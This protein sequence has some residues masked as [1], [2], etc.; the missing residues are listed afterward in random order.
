MQLN[1]RMLIKTAGATALSGLAITGGVNLQQPG[2]PYTAYGQGP[3]QFQKVD[4]ADVHIAMG[5]FYFQVVDVEDGEVTDRQGKNALIEL[6]SAQELLVRFFNEGNAVHEAHFGRNP[7]PE[8]LKSYQENLF[9]GGAAG[10]GFIGLHLDPGQEGMLH[11]WLPESSQGEWEM[12]CFIPGHYEAGMA[13]PL[14]VT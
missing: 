4:Q 5:E 12:G 9:G 14:Q 3:E 1:R 10:S 6:P 11:L 13:A 8:S 2:S 7:D